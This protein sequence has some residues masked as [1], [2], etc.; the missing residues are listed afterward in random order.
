MDRIVETP[1][2]ENKGLEAERSLDHYLSLGGSLAEQGRYAEA[3]ECARHLI[4][5][6]DDCAMGHSILG[7]ALHMQGDLS[8]ARAC[9]ERALALEPELRAARHNL[10]LLHAAEGDW[11]GCARSI[12]SG[13]HTQAGRA[14]IGE[15]L[16][17]AMAQRD[18]TSA[19]ALT[20]A[21]AALRH[22]SRWWPVS[23]QLH[24]LTLPIHEPERILTDET[25]EH[26]IAQFEYLI[27][28]GVLTPQFETAIEGYRAVL[29]RR[30]AAGETQ[31]GPLLANDSEMIGDFYNRIIYSRP[32]P[33]VAKALSPSWSPD[34]IEDQYL[35]QAQGVAVIDDFLTAEALTELR[36]FCLESTVWLAN[37]YAHGRLGAIFEDGFSCPLLLQIAEELQ[38]ALPRVIGDN[39]P[40]RQMWGFKTAPHQPG[41]ST[42]HADFAAVNV[43]F[44]ITPDEANLEPDTG[45]LF[46]YDVDAPQHWD[47]DTYNGRDGVIQP[48]L[49]RQH[50]SRLAIPYRQ[51]RAI[52]FNSDLF[53]G[54]DT[55]DFRPEYENRRI[56]VTMLYGERTDDRR[57]LAKPDPFTDPGHG[58][59]RSA[60]FGARRRR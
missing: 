15:C 33:R 16:S 28:R 26:D 54:T 56:N 29:E 18:L 40:L 50:A 10:T 48:F 11:E 14:W 52:V 13:A 17:D 49:R 30:R 25:L 51:N 2:S 27:E 20:R 32:T 31:P 9:Y 53:H 42:T 12:A 41:D 36:A 58:A 37:S 47:F 35:A 3:E 8:G 22:G 21:V 1:V 38:S 7:F 44:W 59:W 6:T 46:I 4:E 19:G 55:V 43:N 23:A 39:N 24:D 60:V 34:E 5:L 57:R 45:G